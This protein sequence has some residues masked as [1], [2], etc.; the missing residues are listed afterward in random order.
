M[1]NNMGNII[2]NLNELGLTKS[3]A[4]IYLAILEL[5]K[6]NVSKIN[7]QTKINRRNIYDSL[8]TLLDKGLIFQIIGDQKGTYSG[9]NPEKL[10]DLVHSKEILL[11]KILPEM[12]MRFDERKIK[13]NAIIYKGIDGFKNY[14][15]RI[16]NEKQDVYVLG[17][18]RAQRHEI[19]GDTSD[20]FQAERI[21]N[22]IKLYNLY[23]HEMK[24]V[25]QKN[26]N[27]ET[28][29]LTEHRFLPKDFSTN[30]VLDSFGD[31][32]V[33]FTGIAPERFRED[34][35]IFV[36]QSKDLAESWKTWFQFLWDSSK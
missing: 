20:W 14:L 9:I 1:T 29:P 16:L 17:A 31:Q 19:L 32:V 33:T 26:K 18:K 13:E 10:M 15:E 8:S 21:R 5:G 11:E 3:E 35:T 12:K 23:D 28:P 36:I 22:N 27:F 30:S 4:Q 2:S 6:T 7:E 25:L 24:S 34:I